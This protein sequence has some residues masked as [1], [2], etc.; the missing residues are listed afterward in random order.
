MDSLASC[1]TSQKDYFSANHST[2]P[3]HHCTQQRS[4]SDRIK[5]L[6]YTLY[7]LTETHGHFYCFK[8]F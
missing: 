6:W 5:K 1:F 2:I 3:L 7:W 4:E 8:L